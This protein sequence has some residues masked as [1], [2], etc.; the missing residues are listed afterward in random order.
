MNARPLAW[1]LLCAAS[2]ATSAP[3]QSAPPGPAKPP[4]RGI[5]V[6]TH[7]SGRDWGTAAIDR[8]FDDLAAV[9]ANWVCIH[10]YARIHRSGRVTWDTFTSDA[11]PAYLTRPIA[12]AHRRGLKVFVKPH[13]A[14]WGSPFRWRGEITFDDATRWNRFF[15][16][17]RQ[18]IVAVAAACSKADGFAVGTELDKTAVHTAQWRAIIRAVRE[19]TRAPLTYAANWSDYQR[20]GFWDALDIIGVQAYF[21]LADRRDAPDELLRAGWRRVMEEVRTF[22]V[23]QRRNVVFTEL[24]YTNSFRAAIEPW[25]SH[26]DGRDAEPFQRR[27]MAVALRAIEDEPR[28][29]GAFLWKWFPPP[30]ST[31]RDFRIATPEMQRTIAEVWRHPAS[32]RPAAGATHRGATDRGATDRGR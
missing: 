6:S 1:S 8:C 27:L 21:P 18:W 15:T 13:L 23:R 17:Y 7:G 5:T 10:P 9:H 16:H 31:G 12:E 25:A 28:V 26:S 29:E 19:V 24:G 3:A 14:Y 2:L 22:A 32:P 11:P 4:I 20:I 30:R